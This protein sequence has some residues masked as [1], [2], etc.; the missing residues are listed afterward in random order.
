MFISDHSIGDHSRKQ[1]LDRSQHCNGKSRRQQVLNGC[2]I[3]MDEGKSRK[4]AAELCKFGDVFVTACVKDAMLENKT[5]SF[6]K[7]KASIK[8]KKA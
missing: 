3:D 2:K 6:L 4:E 8:E 7:D 5:I 1:R